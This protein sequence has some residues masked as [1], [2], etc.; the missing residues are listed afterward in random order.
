MIQDGS[1]FVTYVPTRLVEPNPWNP[2]RQDAFIYEKEKAS[3][4]KFGFVV[5]ITVRRLA[6]HSLRYQVI[7]GEHRLKAA[8]DL[9]IEEVPIIDLGSVDDDTAKQLTIILNET[10]GQA[11]PDLLKT[12][13]A[14]LLARK[15]KA[16][17]LKVLPYTS[18]QFD[19]MTNAFDWDKVEKQTPPKE[20][21]VMRSYRMPADAAAV[22]DA[23]I[24][25]VQ[26]DSPCPDWQAIERLAADYIAG[27]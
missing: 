25:K 9:K 17:L 1:L 14:D 22:L 20:R 12:L 27:D 11:Q 4:T 10:K 3:I 18:L 24:G 26:E 8:G 13:L 2:N 21:W 15:P 5:P 23:A 19:T 7:D 16:D 6:T